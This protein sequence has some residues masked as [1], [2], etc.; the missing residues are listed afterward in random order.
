MSWSVVLNG[1]PCM[2]MQLAA[3]GTPPVLSG[4]TRC[5]ISGM[6]A[7]KISM[8][9]SPMLCLLWAMARLHDIKR[10][11]GHLIFLENGF[12]FTKCCHPSSFIPLTDHLNFRNIFYTKVKNTFL[13][14]IFYINRTNFGDAGLEDVDV[15]L[16]RVVLVVCYG[17]DTQFYK[18]TAGF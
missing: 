13:D 6:S 12:Y 17:A 5:T 2:R 16:A 11:Y 8:Y 4:W 14:R 1:S 9:L 10:K 18:K 3:P 7:S 15:A